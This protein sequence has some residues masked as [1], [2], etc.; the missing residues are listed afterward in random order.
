MLLKHYLDQGL[1]KAELA[2]RFG[3]DRR[4]IHNWIASGQLER[5]EAAGEVRYKPRSCRPHRA[6][7]K[8]KVERPVDRFERD[9]RGVPKPLAR[10]PHRGTKAH[11][12]ADAAPQ[13]VPRID[14]ERR[15]LP[16]YAA[17]VR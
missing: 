16:D 10:Q 6:Q 11:R 3:V 8:G 4:T 12:L 7:T 14:V 17:L 15:P 13:W 5:D 2:H 9:E 1:T